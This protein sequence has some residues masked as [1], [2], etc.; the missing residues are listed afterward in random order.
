MVLQTLVQKSSLVCNTSH[1]P[2]VRGGRLGGEDVD[3]GKVSHVDPRRPWAEHPRLAFQPR[4]HGRHSLRSE[5]ISAALHWGRVTL[6]LQ[7]LIA[8]NLTNDT[9]LHLEH[10]DGGLRPVGQEGARDGASQ[11]RHDLNALGLGPLP[12]RPLRQHLMMGSPG[13]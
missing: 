6:P 1:G 4:L 13:R 11:D 9:T 3:T 12:C 10:A 2:A 8:R 7:P 5:S